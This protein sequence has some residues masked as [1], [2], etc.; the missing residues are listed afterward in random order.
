[1]SLNELVAAAIAGEMKAVGRLARSPHRAVANAL[2][3]VALRT[4]SVTV[5]QRA[6]YVLARRTKDPRA[7]AALARLLRE[8][9][10]RRESCLETAALALAARKEPAALVAAVAC[11]RALKPGGRPHF[12]LIETLANRTERDRTVRESAAVIERMLEVAESRVDERS[13]A[14]WALFRI[15]QPRTTP[16]LIRLLRDRDTYVRDTAARALVRIGRPDAIAAVTSFLERC[17]DAEL[18]TELRT[19][20]AKRR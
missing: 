3:D 7:I 10:P 4:R 14:V 18:V 8:G 2:A 11:S 5:A 15:A 20:L 12:F 9:D 13:D 6:A 17:K 19:A 1:M 16:R